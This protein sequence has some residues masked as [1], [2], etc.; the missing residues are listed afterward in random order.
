MSLGELLSYFIVGLVGF[1]SKVCFEIFHT[2]Y[3]K[4]RIGEPIKEFRVP[5]PLPFASRD[6]NEPS[7]ED[8]MRVDFT[9]RDVK[10][11]GKEFVSA[12]YQFTQEEFFSKKHY[13][14]FEIVSIEGNFNQIDLEVKTRPLGKPLEKIDTICIKIKP[15]ETK[16]I[17]VPLKKYKGG[18][19]KI[20]REFC[21]VVWDAYKINQDKV[22]YGRYSLRNVKFMGE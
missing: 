5:Y 6:A 22:C 20:L 7:I 9:F 1:G 14:E 21:F 13:F 8:D 15:G 19:L 10:K 12:V 17:T 2:W 18:Q 3:K 11:K 4:K 16:V